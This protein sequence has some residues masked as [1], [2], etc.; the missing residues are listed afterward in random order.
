MARP[1]LLTDDV[2]A[3]VVDA[4]KRGNFR[5]PAARYAGVSFGTMCNWMSYG[6]KNPDSIYGK[7]REAV[8]LAEQEAELTVVDRI[9]RASE[10]DLKAAFWFLERRFPERWS[11]DSFTVKQILR[12]MAEL[13]E[14]LNA[15]SG[16]TLPTPEATQET[17]R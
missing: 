7:F 2:T 6:K 15:V 13:K 16:P 1:S 17:P 4:L 3:K 5:E 10:S 11:K 14:K 9:M 8:I 12:E